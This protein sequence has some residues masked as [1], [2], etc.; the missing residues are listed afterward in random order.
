MRSGVGPLSLLVDALRDRLLESGFFGV[1]K[2]PWL[3]S[4]LEI[5][6]STGAASLERSTRLLFR[7]LRC[8][9][10]SFVEDFPG[11]SCGWFVSCRWPFV[12][13]DFV[14]VLHFVLDFSGV[15]GDEDSDSS[16]TDILSVSEVLPRL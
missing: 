7:G 6:V 5:G 10:A 2:S 12:V 9:C 8:F 3:R 4:L 15:A 14:F 16:P 11:G 13:F 1:S